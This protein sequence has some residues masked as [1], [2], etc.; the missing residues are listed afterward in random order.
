MGAAMI[1]MFPACGCRVAVAC[2][3]ILVYTDLQRPWRPFDST[4]RPLPNTLAVPSKQPVT[5]LAE[6]FYVSPRR[7]MSSLPALSRTPSRAE[8]RQG[9]AM[10]AGAK[11]A[12]ARL[13][14][15]VCVIL[16]SGSPTF[17]STARVGVLGLRPLGWF[18]LTVRHSG[19]RRCWC[20]RQDGRAAAR[21]RK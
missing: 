17:L 16:V 8:A 7:R 9:A 18:A 21:V 11:F 19:Y 14:E 13:G 15:C 4:S 12:M 20:G 10:L 2:S 6:L 3:N 1:I 5:R